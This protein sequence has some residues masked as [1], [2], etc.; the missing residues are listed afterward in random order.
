MS[1]TIEKTASEIAAEEEMLSRMRSANKVMKM[2]AELL[3]SLPD[4]FGG[5]LDQKKLD[6]LSEPRCQEIYL[7]IKELNLSIEEVQGGIQ[8]VDVFSNMTLK[9]C[10]RFGQ[11]RLREL[12]KLSYGHYEPEKEMGMKD[13]IDLIAEKQKETAE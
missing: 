7:K 3:L 11:N 4:D 5:V 9:S 13:M 6:K 10:E 12:N 8:Y 1:D 2:F